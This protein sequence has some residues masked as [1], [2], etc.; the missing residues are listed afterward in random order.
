MLAMQPQMYGWTCSAC[1]LTWVMQATD[2]E[3]DYTRPRAVQEIGYTEQI[4][5]QVGL[6]NADGPGQA[7]RDVLESYEQE[8]M[9]GW[10]DFDTVYELAKTNT[11][12]MS[13]GEWN[14]WVAI[15]GTYGDALWVAN[16]APGYRGIYDVV[17]RADF[18][19]L[20]PMNVVMLT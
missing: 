9:Q 5:P 13:G 1:S 4:N 16:S 15:R 3:P 20:G 17:T 18:E 10:L 7:L 11:G 19:R 8:T 12:M 14:H 2:L 6:T